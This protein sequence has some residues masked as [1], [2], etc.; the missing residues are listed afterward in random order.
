MKMQG[1]SPSDAR[2]QVPVIDATVPEQFR[3]LVESVSDYAIYM[4]DE[5]GHVRSWNAGAQR[6]KGYTAE[7]IV[8][9]HFSLFYLPEDVT[10][11]RFERLLQHA[12]ANGHVEDEGP[13]VR[14]DGST[15]WANVVITAVRDASGKLIGFAKITRDLTERH[16]REREQ[17]E[18]AEARGEKRLR[19]EFLAMISHELRTPLNSIVGWTSLLRDRLRDD[20]RTMADTILRSARAQARL[21]EDLLDMSRSIAGKLALE[22]TTVDLGTLTQEV[23]EALTPT[24]TQKNLSLVLEATSGCAVDGDAPR[25]RQTITNVIGNAV[26]F[27]DAGSI[28]VKVTHEA[29]AVILTVTDPGHGITPEFLPRIFERFQ[30]QDGSRTREFGG[31]GLGLSIA[32]DIVTLH[33]GTIEAHS[34]GRGKGARFTIRLPR[35]ALARP[36]AEIRRHGPRLDGLRVL[37]VDDDADS[38]ALLVAVLHGRGATVISAKTAAEARGAVAASTI[39]AIVSDIGL[40]GEDGFDLLRSLRAKGL[41]APAFALSG[42]S[43]DVTR[44]QASQAGFTDL[45]TKPWEANALVALLARLLPAGR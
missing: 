23:I 27:T 14:K 22:R 2:R 33:D 17:L 28:Q 15:F 6:I 31:L 37:V 30:Q 20:E 45:I 12:A 13:R 21:I 25:L 43:G 39:D 1:M 16:E 8:G 40:P 9:R 3:L 10:A 24:A 41:R 35:V 26:K 4:L 44:A 32:R 36:S 18:L 42:Y 19:D 38:L 29:G 7:E 5:R 34:E 11:G